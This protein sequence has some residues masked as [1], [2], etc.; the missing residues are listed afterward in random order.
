[1]VKSLRNTGFYQLLYPSYWHYLIHRKNL[2]QNMTCYYSAVP[3]PGAGIGHQ[4]ANWIAGYWF[5]EQFGLKYAHTPFSDENWERFLGFGDDET[6]TRDLIRNGHRIIRLPLFNEFKPKEVQ[7]NQ[8]IIGSYIN[9]KIIFVAEQDQFLKDQFKVMNAIKSKFYNAEARSQNRL[10][11]SR[12]NFNI[13][14]HIR[15]GDVSN[16]RKNN[17]NLTMRWQNNKYFEE[18]LASV[19]GGLKQRKPIAIYI[20]SQGVR[21]DFLEFEKFENVTFCLGMNVQESFLHLVYADLLITSKSSFSYKP[22]LL[23]NGIKVCP[24]NFWHGYPDTEDFLMADDY[25]NLDY[26]ELSK[27]L[28]TN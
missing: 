17:P 4:I 16:V 14:I 28:S 25:G 8:C 20:F 22:A 15:R 23:N 19:I 21:E 1:M 7:L 9:N 12:D 10:I 6:R 13:A 24:K 18:V 2:K 26:R 5:A 3:N 11:Y 27:L